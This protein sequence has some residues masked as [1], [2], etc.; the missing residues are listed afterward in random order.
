VVANVNEIVALVNQSIETR[1]RWRA[2]SCRCAPRPAASAFALRELAAR[3]RDLYGLDVNFRAKYGRSSTLNETDASHLYRIAQEALTNTARHGH[4][5]RVDIVLRRANSFMLRITDDGQGF[6]LPATSTGMGLK[7]MKYR[8]GMIGA[9][10][11][12]GAN[13]P[14]GTVVGGGEQPVPGRGLS[15]SC[16]F[17]ESE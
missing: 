14:R 13:E 3:G 15:Q 11:E 17:Q 4:A 5:S 16:E 10:F 9:K 8:A 7:I 2:G 1:A 12:I 6:R